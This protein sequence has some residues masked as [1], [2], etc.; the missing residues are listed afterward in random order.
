M[1]IPCPIFSGGT[2]YITVH[3]RQSDGDVKVIHQPTGGAW[4]GVKVDEKF[5]E[6]LEDVLGKGVLEELRKTDLEDY[7]TLIRE[8]ENKKRSDPISTNRLTTVRIPSSLIQIA[9]KRQKDNSTSGNTEAFRADKLRIDSSI[10]KGW[11]ETTVRPLLTHIK[12]LLI[13]ENIEDVRTIMLVGG[14]AESLYVQNRLKEELTGINIIV[15]EEAG[16]AVVKGAVIFGQRPYIFTSRVMKYTYGIEVY[17]KFDERMHPK[18]KLVIKNGIKKVKN[19]FQPFVRA[20]EGIPADH[21]VTHYITPMAFSD[22]CIQIS[23][24]ES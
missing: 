24:G 1:C 22:F 21:C 9:R 6:Y 15:P 14:Y 7:Y 19:C 16:L 11:F 2:A 5:F 18:E 17:D 13:Q 8:F 3:E 4:G 10:V 20:N 23:I 12:N